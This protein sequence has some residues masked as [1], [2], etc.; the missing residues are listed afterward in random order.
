MLIL[1][2]TFGFIGLKDKVEKVCDLMGL[3]P[4]DL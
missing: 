3:L 1:Q 2:N 4:W